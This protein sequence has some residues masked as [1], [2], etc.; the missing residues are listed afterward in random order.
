MTIAESLAR[1][2]A[3][4]LWAPTVAADPRKRSR[5]TNRRGSKPTPTTLLF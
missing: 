5:G 3:P 2:V 4:P 1:L